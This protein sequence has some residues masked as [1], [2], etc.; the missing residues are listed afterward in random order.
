MKASAAAGNWTAAAQRHTKRCAFLPHPPV[1]LATAAW[2]LS[3]R[4]YDRARWPV[5]C[6]TH[7]LGASK[8]FRGSHW[9]DEAQ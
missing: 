8:S 2:P 3:M 5:M 1:R 6:V 7:L 4:L 9:G